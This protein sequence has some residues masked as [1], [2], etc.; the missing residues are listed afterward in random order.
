[1]LTLRLRAKPFLLTI[2]LSE[3]ITCNK[4]VVCLV[5]NLKYNKKALPE[6]NHWTQ[7]RLHPPERASCAQEAVRLNALSLP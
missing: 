7:V 4:R 2:V 6:S 1:V 5:F 3:T